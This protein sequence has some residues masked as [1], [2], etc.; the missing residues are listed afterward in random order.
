MTGPAATVAALPQ[1]MWRNVRFGPDGRPSADLNGC[2]VHRNVC[3]LIRWPDG[4]EECLFCA[5]DR[6]PA[7]ATANP[8][9]NLPPFVEWMQ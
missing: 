7:M 4:Q 3:D 1:R 5:R 8:A 2:A 6:Q 9:F